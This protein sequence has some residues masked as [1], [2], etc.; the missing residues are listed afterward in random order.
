MLQ[1][2]LVVTFGADDDLIAGLRRLIGLFVSRQA[3]VEATGQ[4]C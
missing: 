2:M 1:R 4:K 3:D